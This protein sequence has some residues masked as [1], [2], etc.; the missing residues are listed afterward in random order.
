LFEPPFVL[1]WV[2]LAFCVAACVPPWAP[3]CVKICTTN[4]LLFALVVV[5]SWVIEQ[6]CVMPLAVLVSE[7]V[8]VPPPY[9]MIVQSLGDD[10]EVRG[11]QK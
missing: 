1:F 9:C 4:A 5:F 7:Q 10:P 2:I 6:F 8:A 11:A 3:L